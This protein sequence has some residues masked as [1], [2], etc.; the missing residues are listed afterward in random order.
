MRLS[1]RNRF[2]IP[3]VGLIVLGMSISAAVSY[4]KAKAALTSAITSQINQLG[5]STINVLSSWLRDRKRDIDYWSN[6]KAYQTAVQDSFVG[7]A[8][9]KAADARLAVLKTDFKFYEEICIA[10][11]K[12]DVISASNPNIVNKLNVTDREYFK[13]AMKGQVVV[14]DVVQSKGTGNP[15]F[16]I[17]A[18]LKEGDKITGV[19][20]GVVDVASFSKMFIDPVKIGQGGYAYVV[21]KEGLI[22]AHPDKSLMMKENISSYEWGKEM[23]AKGDG[24]TTYTWKGTEKLVAQRKEKELGWTLA[25]GTSTAEVFAPIKS[26]GYVN[27]TVAGSITLLAAVVILLLVRSTV[28]PINRVIAGL[29]EAAEQVASGSNEVASSSQQLAEG[30]SQQ[31]AALE[32]SSSSLEEMTSMTRQ[33]ASNAGHANSLMKEAIQVVSKAN[34]SMR[35][36]TSSMQEI[37]RAS[38]ET[39]KIIKTIDE[40]AFQTN[41]LALNAAVEA[42]RAGEAGAGFAVVADEVRNLAMRAADAARNTASLIEG[43]VK[44]V[45]EGGQLVARTNEDFSEVA[46]TSGKVDELVSEI[47]AASNEQAQG[48]EQVN[49]AVAEMDKVTQQ[50]A[51]IAEESSGASEEMSTQAGRMKQFVEQLINIVGGSANQ[52]NNGKT[53]RQPSVEAGEEQAAVARIHPH[54]AGQRRL[55]LTEQ[56]IRPERVIPMDD[57]ASFGDF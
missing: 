47:A 54:K 12:G 15:V 20:F 14:T 11:T 34:D 32:E 23:L 53:S 33:N 6:D 48:I 3:T 10:N 28:N 56:K 41:L 5:D 9:R 30:S 8:A 45:Q 49:R 29:G 17:A 38:E 51:A 27:L 24:L 44:K 25:I 36:L 7:Q 18:P 55:A 31:A 22:I 35:Q 42:A 19:L 2:L 16:M 40:I 43:T 50:T 39:S 13:E 37:S 52:A 57:D 21:N 46:K 4:T 1:L 26:L